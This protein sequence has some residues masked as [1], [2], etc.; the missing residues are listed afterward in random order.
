MKYLTPPVMLNQK[1][2]SKIRVWIFAIFC[3]FAILLL[4]FDLWLAQNF[5]V[6]KVEGRSMENTLF[7]GDYL[8]AD[9]KVSAEHGDIIIINM[10]DRP[11]IDSDCIIKRLIA[12]EGDTVRC[13]GG[14]VSVKYAGETEFTRLNEPYAKGLTTDFT[15]VSVGEGEIFFLGD[16]RSISLDSRKLGCSPKTDIIGVVPQ[17]SVSVKA[18]VTGWESFRNFLFGTEQSHI[19]K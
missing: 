15:E 13:E 5:I 14:V 12:T 18:V 9:K 16:H 7:S 19:S 3:V 6:V 2:E 11:D 8:Y 4:C 10:E 1:K 17:W